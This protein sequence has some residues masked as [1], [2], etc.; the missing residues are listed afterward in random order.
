MAAQAPKRPFA[1]GDAFREGPSVQ[2]L[3]GISPSLRALLLETGKLLW[4][5][6]SITV[7]QAS[8]AF[9]I[10]APKPSADGYD[11]SFC[12]FLGEDFSRSNVAASCE[13]V[14]KLV[15]SNAHC[16]ALIVGDVCDEAAF[17]EWQCMAIQVSSAAEAEA[18]ANS[19]E[20]VSRPRL[21]CLH[22]DPLSSED[23]PTA[24]AAPAPTA[25][26][27]AWTARAAAS[28]V[29]TVHSVSGRLSKT[30]RVA[31]SDRWEGYAADERTPE[32]LA[33]FLAHTL[34]HS[35]LA[36]ELGYAAPIPLSVAHE[37]L[38]YYGKSSSP[39]SPPCVCLLVGL[40]HGPPSL[41]PSLTRVHA[42]AG[43]LSAL[44][45]AMWAH[46]GAGGGGQ[47]DDQGDRVMDGHTGALAAA[48][49]GAAAQLWQDLALDRRTALALAALFLA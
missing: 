9:D 39:L 46:R 29:H 41:T 19:A 40:S 21:L 17:T 5:D 10:R 1:V 30:S 7:R 2:A 45:S 33:A 13:G 8:A 20:A 15:R 31:V 11:V 48:M 36:G 27:A 49:E 37:A 44:A 23:T 47:P 16:V 26:S 6:Q 34:P 25:G 12:V 43:S 24:T 28:V 32:A 38:L 18:A 4:K 42:C 3:P 35:A 22:V 14:A